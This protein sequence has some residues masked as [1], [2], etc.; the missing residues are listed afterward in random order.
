MHY[1]CIKYFNA[2][3]K[4]LNFN[5]KLFSINKEKLHKLFNSLLK[6]IHMCIY[7]KTFHYKKKHYNN[8]V[9][10]YILRIGFINI[11]SI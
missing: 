4:T 8:V 6:L 11:V 9:L 7:K 3:Y 10:F 5:L 2:W 1:V